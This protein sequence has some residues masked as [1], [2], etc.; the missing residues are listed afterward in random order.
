MVDWQLSI[1]QW[2]LADKNNRTFLQS[3]P[4]FIFRLDIIDKEE[5][6]GGRRV[7]QQWFKLTYSQ[8]QD[9]R[10]VIQMSMICL[11]IGSVP[12]CTTRW[13]CVHRQILSP[14]EC[15]DTSPSLFLSLL[16]SHYFP[17][18]DP[19]LIPNNGEF[20]RRILFSRLRQT[21]IRYDGKKNTFWNSM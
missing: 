12:F 5:T 20:I 6:G 15:F 19:A 3:V 2:L 1:P 8:C 14:D 21:I 9:R 10:H 4:V 13:Q 7:K 18:D 16:F 17:G 11:L